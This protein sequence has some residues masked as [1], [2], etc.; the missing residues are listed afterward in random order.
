MVLEHIGVAVKNP[1]E[2]ARWYEKNL[3]CIIQR[4][5]HKGPGM[6]MSFIS[7][8]KA[9]SV[10]ELLCHPDYKP[11]SD[12]LS[13]AAQLHFAFLSDDP[14]ADS[15]RLAKA[16]ATPCGGGPAAN[17]EILLYLKDPWGNFIQLVKRAKPLIEK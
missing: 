2:M 11:V 13:G 5:G 14:Y 8:D 17:G 7:D 4:E 15:D 1:P 9:K 16:G 6:D 3:G 12:V 10:L